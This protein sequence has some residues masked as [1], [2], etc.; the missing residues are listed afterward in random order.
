MTQ[1]PLL[2]KD[3]RIIDGNG[4][5]PLYNQSVLVKGGR[6]AD[7]AL[8]ASLSTPSDGAEIDLSGKTL[9]PG[10]IDCH[11]H[12]LGNP[13]PRLA[14]RPSNVP[15][16]DDAYMKGRS[17]LYAVTASRATQLTLPSF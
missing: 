10:F 16:R 3:A 2:L 6:I 7:V 14:P 13:D 1:T 8:A 9:L 4:G 11:V 12:I 5:A 17:L 15:I